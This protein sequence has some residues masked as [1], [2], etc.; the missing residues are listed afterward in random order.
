M[1]LQERMKK[2]AEL[3]AKRTQGEWYA[4]RYDDACY[5][6]DGIPRDGWRLD[7][8]SYVPDYEN[9]MLSEHDCEFAAS[10]P[11]MYTDLQATVRALEVAVY[12]LSDNELLP[13]IINVLRNGMPM[14]YFYRDAL[15]NNL[16]AV[17]NNQNKAL[18]LINQTLGKEGV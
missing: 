4:K 18:Q 13:D 16:E 12:G 10:A 1:S 9:P 3:D 8:V 6:E 11:S 5:F 7:G 17:L 2:Y 15:A 14:E